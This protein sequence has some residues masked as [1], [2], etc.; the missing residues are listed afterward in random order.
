MTR[1]THLVSD[2]MTEELGG[3]FA[4]PPPEGWIELDTRIYTRAKVKAGLVSLANDPSAEIDLHAFYAPFEGIR[5]STNRVYS[6][7]YSNME[8]LRAVGRDIA[9]AA[10]ALMPDDELDVLAFGCTSAAMALGTDR[11]ASDIH[12]HKPGVIVTD[13]IS[14][15]LAGLK[16][17]QATRIAVITPYIGEVNVGIAELLEACGLT[18]TSKGFFRIFDD[19]QRNRVSLDSYLAAAKTVTRDA[20]CDA[21]FISC[22][23]M[24]T[25]PVIQAIED[26]TGIPVVTSNQALAW[27]VMRLGGHAGTT[28][29]FGRLFTV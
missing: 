23:A 18:L 11:V 2:E 26:A 10:A 8:S 21:I 27:N 4:A 13:P 20:P 22:T 15:I 19:N 3:E 29:R 7:Q 9:A 1:Q 17:L 28:D 5:L 14:S 25:A 16:A 6:P 24:A 12:K